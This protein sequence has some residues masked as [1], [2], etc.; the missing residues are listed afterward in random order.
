[1]MKHLGYLKLANYF[2]A[3]FYAA[4]GLLIF[5]LCWIALS[6]VPA[7]LATHDWPMVFGAGLVGMLVCL[8]L[9]AFAFI[10]GRNVAEGRWRLPQTVWAVLCLGNNPPIGL[11]YG[12]YA[13]WVCWANSETREVFDS[14]G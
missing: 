12:L 7:D 5:P 14:V 10:M 9:A 6:L 11:A 2:M 8:G 4:A 1:M 13:L 3:T